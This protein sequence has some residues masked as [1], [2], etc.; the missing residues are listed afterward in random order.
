MDPSARALLVSESRELLAEMERTL[1]ALEQAGDS[2][3][4]INAAFRAAHT[5]KGAAGLFELQLITGFT[6]TLESVL[7]RIR[8]GELQADADFIS[9]LLSCCDYLELLVDAIERE[10]E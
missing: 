1:L 3:D 5:I 10:Q 6:Q 7:D 8:R 9:L 2:A 4:V